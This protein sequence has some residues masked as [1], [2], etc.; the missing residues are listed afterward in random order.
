MEHP[1][2][3]QS[4]SA[5]VL[6]WNQSRVCLCAQPVAHLDEQRYVVR[7]SV[8]V[9]VFFS[10]PTVRRFYSHTCCF[11]KA[12]DLRFQM[13]NIILV[14]FR[15]FS[16]ALIDRS[17]R[18]ANDRFITTRRYYFRPV[19]TLLFAVKNVRCNRLLSLLESLLGGKTNTPPTVFV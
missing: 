4:S 3:V 7:L 8:H 9:H 11:R 1:D 6:T 18:N 15:R 5:E 10:V 19:F 13:E 16:G 2:G 12:V 14:S 17:V